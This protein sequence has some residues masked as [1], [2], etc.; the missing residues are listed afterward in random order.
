MQSDVFSCFGH[1]VNKKLL[2]IIEPR[3]GSG[4]YI[5]VFRRQ[6]GGYSG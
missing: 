2:L 1:T 3:C 6:T 5:V 4:S